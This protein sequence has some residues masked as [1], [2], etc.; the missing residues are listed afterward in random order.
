MLSSQICRKFLFWHVAKIE[1]MQHSP[2]STGN[3]FRQ[4][5]NIDRF[6]WYRRIP[7][8]IS[9]QLV[10]YFHGMGC[11]RVWSIRSNFPEFNQQLFLVVRNASTSATVAQ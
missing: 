1:N 3:N 11:A 10:L 8:S 7:Q 9:F 5:I 2:T 4:D 6:F